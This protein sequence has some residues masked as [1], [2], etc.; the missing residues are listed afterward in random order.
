[1][2][3]LKTILVYMTMV[4]VSSVQSAPDPS[5]VQETPTPAPSSFTSTATVT[6]APTPTPTPVP[7]PNITPN[8]TYKTIK[9]GDKGDEVKLLQ[10]R[11]AEL[12]YYTG[13]VDGVFGNQT[14][15]SVERF[16]YYQGLSV[17]GIA[18][19]RT[20]TVLYESKE[21]VFAPVDVTPTPSAKPTTG[22]TAAIT[23]R[24]ATATPAPTF[25]P[26][27]TAT[28][29]TTTTA[30]TTVQP[31]NKANL[32]AI[33]DGSEIEAESTTPETSESLET[34]MPEASVVPAETAATPALTMLTNQDFVLAGSTDPL[35]LPSPDTT[36]VAN[37]V[38]LH[39]VQDGDQVYV[40]L[41][42]IIRSAGSVIIPGA[43]ATDTQEVAFSLL[44]DVYQISYV[45]DNAGT[46]TNLVV[47]KN[48]TPQIMS[49]RNAFL[50]DSILYLP[51][52]VTTELTGITYTLDEAG[53][54]YTITVPTAPAV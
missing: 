2:D 38:T 24:P 23:A 25:V 22:P 44:N 12:G 52:T 21:V 1:M 36:V 26:V 6:A 41:V 33:N 35:T 43:D 19:K 10:R 4:F 40:P 11:L 39:P 37:P 13:D 32:A 50:L 3:L 51:M 20:Q 34:T 49:T 15:R 7:T 28:V 29:S 31:T 46:V 9:V 47:L 5:L 42:E 45:I 8:D 27:A 14:R 17:D 16:Q 53:T 18:G 54:R 30:M 48:Q